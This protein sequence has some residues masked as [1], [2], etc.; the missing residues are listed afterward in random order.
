MFCFCF[1]LLC[2]FFVYFIYFFCEQLIIYGV[3]LVALNMNKYL[4]YKFW[5]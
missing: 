3:I 2:E 1:A 5:I 4:G